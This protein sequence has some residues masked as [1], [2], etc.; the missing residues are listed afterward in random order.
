MTED[1]ALKETTE[2]WTKLADYAEKGIVKQKEE[3]DGPWQNYYF[4][5]PCCEYVVTETGEFNCT[6]CPMKKQWQTYDPKE[7]CENTYCHATSSPFNKW[8]NAPGIGERVLPY[9]LEFFCRL[10]VELAEE[11][12]KE[13]K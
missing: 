10:I 8:W 11:A 5:C 9:D 6:Y 3:I 1:Q 2:L 13:L 7:E 12:R 4:F